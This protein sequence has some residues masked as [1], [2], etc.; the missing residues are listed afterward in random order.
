MLPIGLSRRNE[1]L[2]RDGPEFW[3]LTARPALRLSDATRVAEPD[4]N[5]ILRDFRVTRDTDDDGEEAI[6]FDEVTAMPL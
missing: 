2:G 4:G 5:V 1:I 6:E 3:P